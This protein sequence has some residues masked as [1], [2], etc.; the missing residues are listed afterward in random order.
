MRIAINYPTAHQPRPSPNIRPAPMG[1]FADIPKRALVRD[2]KGIEIVN[3]LHSHEVLV[4]RGCSKAHF[5]VEQNQRLAMIVLVGCELVKV[6]VLDSAVVT[7]RT[8][9]LVDCTSCIVVAQDA[10]V[11]K[12]ECWNTRESTVVF[13][14]DDALMENGRA[15]WHEGCSGN[16][17]IHGVLEPSVVS[18]AIRFRERVTVSVPASE[19]GTQWATSMMPLEYIH[20]VRLADG[21][22]VSPEG[23]QILS[24]LR[25]M[26]LPALPGDDTLND[27]AALPAAQAVREAVAAL[28]AAPWALSDADVDRAYDDERA[29]WEEPDETFLPKVAAVAALVDKARHCVVYTGAGISTSANIPDFRGPAGVW[30]LRD[31]GVAWGAVGGDYDGARPTLA[32]YAVTELARRGRVRFVT[33]TNMDG[34]H[35]RSGLPRHLV[36]ELHGCMYKL[37]CSRCHA[38]VYSPDDVDRGAPDHRTDDTC[39]WCGGVLLDTIVNFSDTYRSELEPVVALFQAKRADLALVM[40]T[41]MNVQGAASYP[42]KALANPGGAL[43]IVNLQ[44]TPYD[45]LATHRIYAKTDR[46][47]GALMAALGIEQFDTTY[48]SRAEWAREKE[49]REAYRAQRQ[50]QQQQQE[51]QANPLSAVREFL[52]RKPS[53]WP[54]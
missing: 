26:T 21:G 42:E 34:L 13:V 29:E 40:G 25:R 52:G 1:A 23:A 31:K 46:F 5:I 36:E 41:S 7:S 2:G 3:G 32:H 6:S 53:W 47:M 28:E 24:E 16:K 12:V 9:R 51:G 48:D 38:F 17:L 44:H 45:H 14:G 50:R 39:C 54:L 37:F 22:A 8:V 4:L 11:R 20:N 15:I 33:T 35:V 18:W 49:A 27:P 43:V 10:D 19:N 30:T